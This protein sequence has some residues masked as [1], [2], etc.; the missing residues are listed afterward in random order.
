VEKL[1]TW[2]MAISKMELKAD[3]PLYADQH[4]QPGVHM[5]KTRPR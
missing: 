2:A 5:E 4:E 1:F 3:Y